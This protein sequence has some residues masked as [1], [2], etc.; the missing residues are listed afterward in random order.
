MIAESPPA[1][2]DRRPGARAR[3]INAACDHF[4]AAWCGGQ[5]PRIEDVLAGATEADRPVLLRELIALEVELRRGRGEHPTLGEYRDRFA[6][7]TAAVEDALANTASRSGS[8]QRH[9]DS[10]RADTG[11]NLLLGLLALKN[12]FIDRD[13]LLAGFGSWVAD[14]S[15]PLGQILLEGGALSPGHHL[16]LEAL[17]AEYLA[18]YGDDPDES[19]AALGSIGSVRDDLEQLADADLQ[20]CLAIV[21]SGS[22][23]TTA[24]T[25]LT[26]SLSAPGGPHTNGAAAGREASTVTARIGK[27]QIVR[28]LGSG[29]QASAL[30]A[31]DPDLRRHVV[32][33][34]Y[35]ATAAPGGEEAALRE[36]QAL[37]RVHSPYVARCLGV[38]RVGR[39]VYL[40]MEY[41][42]GDDLARYQGRSPLGPTAAAELI[43]RLA[44]GLAAVHA[45]GLLHRD[46]K[47]SNIL[48]GDDG[49]PRLVDFGLAVPLASTALSG[50]SGTLPYMSPEQARGEP[51]RIDPRTD[52]F[53][54]GAVLY[55]LLTGR[56]PYQGKDREEV[57]Q[58]AEQCRYEPPRRI[59]AAVPVGL[60][61]ICLKAMAAAPENRYAS[62]SELQRAMRRD[63]RWRRA[64]PV[65]VIGV[66]VLLLLGLAWGSWK[67]ATPAIAPRILSLEIRHWLRG[68]EKG[69]YSGSGILGDQSFSA[70]LNDDMTVQAELSEPAYSYL[71][72]FR[73]DG[74][75]EV[76]EPED[77]GTAPI[78]TDHPQYPPP[79]KSDVVYR[80]SE[81]A[82]LYAFALVVS[83]A[84]L[85]P[86]REWEARHGKAPW[87]KGQEADP[88]VVWRHDGRW[89][90]PLTAQGP[91]SERARGR[92]A[93]GA[94]PA[95]A[96]LAIWL[97]GLPGVDAVLVEAFAVVDP[98]V[99]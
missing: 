67:L 54:L 64:R 24:G 84:A 85:P 1:D 38:E 31:F 88:G 21:A 74:L 11:R 56:P 40:V 72:A 48:I 68:G 59:R 81:G 7:Q 49:V 69:R 83:R 32:L 73:P 42:A 39:A 98:S 35:H 50:I 43:E 34:R 55:E 16:F 57:W 89:L 10:T 95:V 45:C 36:G 51:E 47:P 37:V 17:I 14:R 86:F 61:R 96:R 2:E 28:P 52:I 80:L 79:S 60:E 29:G 78:K 13:T 87:S 9:P 97:R 33:K 75:V 20:A 5:A 12:D 70:R 26:Q 65:A 27:Y 46:I 82:G 66:A 23:G 15:R 44:E 30:L 25:E 92:E 18:L 19:L 91:N 6:G 62:A 4:E 58:Q 41:I 99:P 22:A 90:V 63:L 93:R 8:R 76:C 53:G 71:L 3:R 94:G 77:E